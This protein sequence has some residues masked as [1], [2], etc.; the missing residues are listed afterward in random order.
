MIETITSM[1]P[2]LLTIAF[3][4]LVIM[5]ML[6]LIKQNKINKLHVLTIPQN[7]KHIF[8]QGI[9]TDTLPNANQAIATGDLVAVQL[10]GSS[11]V[12][13]VAEVLRQHPIKSYVRVVQKAPR[14]WY[15]RTTK[16]L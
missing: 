8:D 2:I 4:L 9:E 7:C 15:L 14:F 12:F 13:G 5:F 10:R 6:Q 16:G 11:N 1:I 3:V